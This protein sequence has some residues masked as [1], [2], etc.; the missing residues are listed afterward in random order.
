MG[1]IRIIIAREYLQKIR[2]KWFFIITILGPLLVAG[3]MFLTVYLSLKENEEQ[4]IIVVDK[5][6]IFSDSLVSTRNIK[7]YNFV[8]T[9]S[10]GRALVTEGD[11]DALLYIPENFGSKSAFTAILEYQKQPSL[12]TIDYLNKLLESRY[13]EYTLKANNV[14]DSV[15][16]LSKMGVKI[17]TKKL[18]DKGNARTEKFEVKMAIGFIGGFAIYFFIFL[19]GVQVMRGVMEEKNNRIVEVIVSSVKPFQLMMGKIIGIALVGLTQFLLWVILSLSITGVLNATVFKQMLN[20]AQQRTDNIEYAEHQG[21]DMK[22][23]SMKNSE[24]PLSLLMKINGLDAIDFNELLICFGLYFLFGYLLYAAMFASIG[25]AVDSDTDTQQFIFPV[26]VPQ[27]IALVAAQF[28]AAN[29]KSDLGFWLSMIPFT[30]PITMMV[31]LPF[32]VPIWQ[33]LLSLTLLT[34]TF[35]IMTW[36][37]AKI[38]RTGILIYGKKVT[39]RELGRW[40]FYK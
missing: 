8:S 17:A 13:F 29:P 2:N 32:G 12:S 15:I 26:T 40:L 6:N 22:L 18:D 34:I 28:I 21:A 37:A 36:L 16:R 24:T 30:S 9:E 10:Q 33:I 4:K 27:V 19:Y 7:F 38:Y 23:T 11:F 39:W 25:S 14:P 5:W 31:R 3:I 35:M 1:K 20:E